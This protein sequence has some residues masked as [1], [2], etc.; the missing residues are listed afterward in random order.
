MHIIIVFI[1]NLI[2]ST[3][4]NLYCALKNNH[5]SSD[6]EEDYYFMKKVIYNLSIS[7]ESQQFS[8]LEKMMLKQ[9]LPQELIN[10][11]ILKPEEILGKITKINTL[12]NSLDII[13]C[14][15]RAS[16]TEIK[17]FI[18][19]TFDQVRYEGLNYLKDKINSKLS[20]SSNQKENK[21]FQW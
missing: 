12:V 20:N 5:L 4:H 6:R 14:L 16:P 3:L 15:Y 9:N 1:M 18:N 7:D 17:N 19:K 10:L 11:L 8:L 21:Y 13:L 2:K